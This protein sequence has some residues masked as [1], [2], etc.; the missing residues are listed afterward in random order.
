LKADILRGISTNSGLAGMLSYYEAVAGDWQYITKFPDLLERVTPGDIMVA[1]EQYLEPR[2][3]T[4]A[5]LV[6]KQ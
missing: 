3:R 2:N 1:A 6:R 4:V 5:E